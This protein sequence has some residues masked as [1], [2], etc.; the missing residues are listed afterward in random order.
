MFRSCESI[1]I[2]WSNDRRGFLRVGVLQITGQN[3][4]SYFNTRNGNMEGGIAY[5]EK[6]VVV[7]PG[8]ESSPSHRAVSGTHPA[9]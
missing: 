2:S 1:H 5:S 4:V 6:A 8:F 9:Y 3:I 7:D